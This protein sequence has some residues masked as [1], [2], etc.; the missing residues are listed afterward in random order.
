VEQTAD[1]VVL[2]R[3]G[4]VVAVD[5]IATMR[6]RSRRRGVA[7][8]QDRADVPRLAQALEATP[9]VTEIDSTET[10][11]TFAL[12]GLVEPLL[13][14]LRDVPMG[15]LDLTH[16]DLEDAFFALYDDPGDSGSDPAEQERSA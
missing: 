3:A 5:D 10:A 8:P 6:L 1:R 13:A 2:M 15:S 14:S 12:D 9:G 11:V 4:R 16:A 7:T